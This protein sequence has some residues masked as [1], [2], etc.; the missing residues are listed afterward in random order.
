LI[1]KEFGDAGA[2]PIKTSLN[3]N[4]QGEPR[5]PLNPWHMGLNGYGDA[6]N[7]QHATKQ[8]ENIVFSSSMDTTATSPA[9]LLD[10]V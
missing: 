3:W 5:E 7:R 1:A 8:Q 2:T 4:I 10:M 9:N 6:L